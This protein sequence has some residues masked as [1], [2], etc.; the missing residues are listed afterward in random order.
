M[1]F[2]RQ[3]PQEYLV[4]INNSRTVCSWHVVVKQQIA[5]EKYD[6]ISFS[7]ADAEG[8]LCKIMQSESSAASNKNAVTWDT[9]KKGKGKGAVNSIMSGEEKLIN[10]FNVA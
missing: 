1:L 5:G 10:I 8:K 4:N 3:N 7:A 2:S 6:R 9:K